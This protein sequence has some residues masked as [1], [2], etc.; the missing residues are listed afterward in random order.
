MPIPI[1]DF[2]GID[3]DPN[4]TDTP[5]PPDPP[6]AGA[7]TVCYGGA[8]PS[9]VKGFWYVV[10]PE[11]LSNFWRIPEKFGLPTKHGQGWY[12][13]ELRDANLDWAGGLVKNAQGDCVLQGL[14]SGALLNVP[15]DWPDPKPGTKIE[16]KRGGPGQLPTK[17]QGYVAIALLV[18]GTLGIAALAVAVA[19]KKR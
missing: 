6:P 8:A 15:G 7:S 3:L 2:D 16:P 9:T 13:H 5:T 4:A 18:A 10:Q 19:R 1:E 11:D 17:R 14:M 12:W